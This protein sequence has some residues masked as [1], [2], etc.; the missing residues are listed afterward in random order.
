MKEIELKPIKA[1][2]SFL[3]LAYARFYKL[4]DTITSDTFFSLDKINRFSYIKDIILVYSELL[5][6]EPI[7]YEI[8]LIKKR[9][10]PMEAEISQDLL[11][12][13][14]NILTH[15][16]LFTHWNEI[17]INKELVNWSKS[18]G[19]INSFL[20]KYS[21]HEQVKYRIWIAK[22]SKMIYIDINFPNIY[23]ESKIFLKNIISEK[24][25]MIFLCYIMKKVLDSQLI[26]HNTK[27]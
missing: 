16:P 7:S 19:F 22:Q 12:F 5:S 23:D 2:L 8:M 11:K 3:N 24:E 26:C 4:F 10:P 6:Y 18:N 13:I 25:G 15:F 1:E 27:K 14:R 21:G 17:W 20:Q 9:R